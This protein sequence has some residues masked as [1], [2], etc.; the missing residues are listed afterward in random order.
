MTA[1]QEK[2]INRAC[3]HENLIS[4]LVDALVAMDDAMCR[5]FDTPEDR[6]FARKAL[7]ANRALVKK[8]K[9]QQQ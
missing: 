1:A 9:E 8:A 4:E 7:I 6:Y 3:G 5:G 2:A